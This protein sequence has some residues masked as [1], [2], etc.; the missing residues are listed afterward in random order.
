M[1]AARAADVR[2]ILMNHIKKI[3][4]I[5]LLLCCCLVSFAQTRRR[6]RDSLPPRPAP[7][8]QTPATPS[9]DQNGRFEGQVYTNTA[10]GFSLTLPEGWQPQ[11][12]ETQR[13]FAEGA[14]QRAQQYGGQSPAA[15]ASVKRTSVLM[16]AVKPTE[17]ITNPS[18]IIAAE[19]IALYF[20][21]R[22]PKQYIEQMRTISRNTPMVVG[23]NV[24][25][26][27]VGGA[28]FGVVDVDFLNAPQPGRAVVKQRYYVTIRKNH[29][30]AMILTYHGPEELQA[31]LDVVKSFKAQ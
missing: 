25:T 23:E 16:I 20:N 15:Q 1:Y 13:R 14:A 10:L 26:E 9:V 29:A 27:T 18:V 24:T 6:T 11:D 30:I 22:T 5:L 2:S 12:T 21:V 17:G 19:D 7:T 31:C 28:M 8:N 3:A 4:T